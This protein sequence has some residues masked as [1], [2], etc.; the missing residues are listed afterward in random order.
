ML[1]GAPRATCTRSA[2]KPCSARGAPPPTWSSS[3]SSRATRRTWRGSRS[4]VRRASCSTARWRPPGSTGRPSPS[5]TPSSTSSGS[6]PPTCKRRIHKKPD[7]REIGACKPWLEAEIAVLRPRLVVALGTTAAQALLGKSFRV[8]ASRGQVLDLP[9]S[10]RIVATVRPSS[11]LRSAGEE[12][13]AVEF[14]RL[15]DDLRVVAREPRRPD[16][17]GA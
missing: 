14:D 5:P 12:N 13:R 6:R 2:R 9:P 7:T 10:S 17:G 15:V 8:T 11:I 1:P 16:R 3:A 4:S